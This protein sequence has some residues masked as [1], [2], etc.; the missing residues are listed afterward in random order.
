[1]AS[2]IS[3]LQPSLYRAATCQYRIWIKSMA[4]IKTSPTHLSL[5]FPT[6]LLLPKHFPITFWRIR[7]SSILTMCPTHCNLSS[8]HIQFLNYRGLII[9]ESNELR[10][11]SCGISGFRRFVNDIFAFLGFYAA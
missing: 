11:D 6:Y 10:L 8:S 4:F 2:P 5:G 7:E 3:F 1:M 9:G